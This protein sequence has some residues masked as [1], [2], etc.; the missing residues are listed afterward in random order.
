MSHKH[1][2]KIR[3]HLIKNDVVEPPLDKV[4]FLNYV[5]FSI[6]V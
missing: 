2:V 1:Y 6:F 3:N 4:V 5:G